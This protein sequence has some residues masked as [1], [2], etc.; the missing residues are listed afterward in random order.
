MYE[1]RVVLIQADDFDEAIE[2]AEKEAKEYSDFGTEYLEYINVYHLCDYILRSGSELYSE[3]R[4][5]DLEP[6]AYISYF[7]DTGLEHSRDKI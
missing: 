6:E 4:S 1:E 7:L 5:S 2:K 3:M